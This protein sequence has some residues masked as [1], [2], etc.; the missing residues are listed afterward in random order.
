MNKSSKEGIIDNIYSGTASFGKVW[1]II[2]AVFAVIIA[3]AMIVGGIYVI[4]HK[5]HLKE[6]QGTVV[7]SSYNCSTHT[8]KDGNKSTSCKVNVQYTVDGERYVKEFS[9]ATQYQQ[10]TEITVYYDPKD[11]HD[12]YIEP[13]PKAIGYLLIFGALLMAGGAI[14]WAYFAQK[15]KVVA[16]AAGAR[17]IYDFIR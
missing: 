2:T 6:V 5:S 17:G 10:G 16:A 4:W 8:D 13:V 15:Y 14:A 9:T 3:I 11:P 7:K 1:S 12:A